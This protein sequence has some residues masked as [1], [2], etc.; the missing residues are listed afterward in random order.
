MFRRL[1]GDETIL[2]RDETIFD[3]GADVPKLPT[4][5][6]VATQRREAPV[7][8]AGDCQMRT[9]S[10]IFAFAFVLIAP[11]L[12]GAPDSG[13]PGVGTF[14]YSGSTAAGSAPSAIVIAAR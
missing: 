11:S 1:A 6:K 3:A 7:A 8:E 14:A 12:A 5:I 9:L 2:R 13:I 4:A 10:F